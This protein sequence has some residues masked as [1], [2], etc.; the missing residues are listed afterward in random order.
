MCSLYVSTVLV[1]LTVQS[2][3]FPVCVK[4]IPYV[5]NVYKKQLIRP[6][7]KIISRKYCIKKRASTSQNDSID[8]LVGK[9]MFLKTLHYNKCHLNVMPP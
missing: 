5:K 1:K 8:R 4:T 6:L 9:I 2:V 7:D 3:L